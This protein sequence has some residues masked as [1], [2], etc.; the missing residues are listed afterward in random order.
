V[1]AVIQGPLILVKLGG[2]D[3]LPA[4]VN[5]CDFRI[6]CANG[7]RFYRSMQFNRVDN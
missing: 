2:M 1:P 4:G 7:E 5:Y 6:D 3:T